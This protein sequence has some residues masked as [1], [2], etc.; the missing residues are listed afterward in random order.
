MNT[1]ITLPAFDLCLR[2]RS[3]SFYH[4]DIRTT[5]NIMTPRVFS[6]N[7]NTKHTFDQ[8]D[9]VKAISVINVNKCKCGYFTFIGSLKHS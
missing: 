5:R 9:P 3:D 6:N 7:T 8:M 4:V 1:K 2:I